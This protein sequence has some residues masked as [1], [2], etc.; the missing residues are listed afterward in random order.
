MDREFKSPTGA[1][2]SGREP[3]VVLGG[4]PFDQG[5]LQR[6]LRRRAIQ[7]KAERDA[8][9]EA[10]IPTGSG[11]PLDATTRARMA[12]HF[13]ASV[14][15][16]ARVHA[17]A[18]SAQAAHELGARAFTDGNHVHFGAG[19]LRPGT[20]EGDR[21]LA[22]ELSHVADGDT[23]TI[24]RKE[25]PGAEDKA[26]VSKPSD[27]AEKK[28]DAKGDAVA[29]ALHADGESDAKP[30]APE[31]FTAMFGWL[32]RWFA[33]R[34][35]AAAGQERKDDGAPEKN[36]G[37]EQ[38]NTGD[39]KDADPSAFGLNLTVTMAPFAAAA[40]EVNA[41]WDSLTPADRL[42]RLRTAANE[43]LATAQVPETKAAMPDLGAGQLGAFDQRGWEIQI[44]KPFVEEKPKD[45]EKASLAE[46]VYHE[47]RH[48]EQHHKIARVLSA[49]GKTA[50]E[51][52]A[53]TDIKVDVV[54]QAMS[55]PK[56]DGAQA[57]LAEQWMKSIH[58]NG[59][60]AAHRE[61]V[62][63]KLRTTATALQKAQQDYDEARKDPQ[64]TPP[65]VL[66]STM[67]ALEN[68]RREHRRAERE[69]KA[70]PEETDAFATQEKLKLLL[71][72]E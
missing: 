52:V 63:G 19:E 29:D 14:V 47:A 54:K 61:A 3:D 37:S 67:N 60:E 5:V 1:A 62:Y 57:G 59:P 64:L 68:A 4:S 9:G 44:N 72:E 8:A 23:S 16:R 25:V 2:P 27:P 53:A 13:G 15:E 34:Q 26:D 51:I 30:I 10:K 40:K 58:G 6:S 55:L 66:R 12:P 50:T 11:R 46:I 70:L 69:Y 20:K 56:L 41:K 7:R 49:Q 35:Q 17:G 24:A 43:Q 31:Q 38:K 36:D 33:K 42:E 48:A 22:H 39:A 21:L 65:E 71:V 28:A 18:D 32:D 45:P